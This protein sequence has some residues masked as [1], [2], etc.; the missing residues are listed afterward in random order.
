MVNSDTG[1]PIC[2]VY[3]VYQSGENWRNKVQN[4]QLF[5]ELIPKWKDEQKIE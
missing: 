4:L 3:P 5:V 1:S 2:P